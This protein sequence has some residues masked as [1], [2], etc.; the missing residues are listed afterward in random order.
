MTASRLLRMVLNRLFR[1]GVH[2][3]SKGKRTDRTF[4]QAQKSVRTI[5]RIRRM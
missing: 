2:R 5:N 1:V 3:V 4:A